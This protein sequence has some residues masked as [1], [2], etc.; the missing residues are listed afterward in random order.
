MNHHPAFE[1]VREQHLDS[2]NITVQEFTHL[3]TGAQHIHIQ[4]D[5]DENVFLVAL[6][7]VPTDSTGVA[8]I[9]EH[10][11]LCGSEKYPVRDPFFMMIRRSLNTF[12]NAFTSSDWTAYP[13]ASTNTKDFNNLLDVYL[14]A[15]FFSRL[16]ELDFLQEGHRLEFEKWDDPSS[17]LQFKGVVY[18][19]MKGA[20]SSVPSQL[21]Q[22]L[23][24]HLHPSNTYHFNSGGDPVEIPDLSYQQLKQFYR[25]H[26]HPSNAIF[27]TFG[28]L[29]VSELQQR[30][31]DQAL[32]R[33]DRLD[34]TIKV[35]SEQPFTAPLT[36]NDVYTAENDEDKSHVV[37]AWLLGE[38]TDPVEALRA[39]LMA[40]LLYENSASPLQQLL[41]TSA[42]GKSPSPLNGIEDSQK[43]IIF[44]AGMEGCEATDRDAIESEILATI[45]QAISEGFA[46]ERINA[47]IDQLELQQ[48]EVGGDG[49]P[50]GLQLI[51][52]SLGSATHRGDPVAV[53]D[54]DRSLNQ[55]REDLKDPN[56]VGETLQRLFIDNTH[57]LTL[58]VEPDTKLAEAQNA[59]EQTRL[60]EIAAALS[61]QEVAA[62]VEQSQ[63][64]QDRQNAEDDPGTLPK[65]GIADVPASIHEPARHEYQGKS[66][67]AYEYEAGTN[68]L[69]YLQA[70]IALPELTES[71][72]QILPFLCNILSELGLGNDDYLHVQNLHTACSGGL[73]AFTSIRNNAFDEQASS[74]YLV[75]SGKGLRRYVN[76][77]TT[78]MQRT[79]TE[80]R[81]DEHERVRDLMSQTRSRKE[82][83][84][85]GNG[86]AYAMGAASATANGLAAMQFATSGLAGI[87]A[88]KL[89]DER[90]ADAAELALFCQ[91]L[92]HL[93]QKLTAVT[94][95][96]AVVG[97]QQYLAAYREALANFQIASEQQHASEWSLPK[98]RTVNSSFWAVNAQVNFCALAFPTVTSAH[99]DAAALT[100]LGG[101]LRNGFLH[102]ALREQ[103]G[104]YGGGANQDNAN[105]V[106][107][108]F[109]Y[110]D[111]RTQETLDDFYA[112]IEWLIDT[113]LSFDKVEES[114]LGVISSL[115]KPASPAGEAKQALSQYLH[116]R[117]P[118]H[119]EAFRTNV[120]NVTAAELKRVAMKYLK[121]TKPSVAIVGPK[122]SYE[123]FEDTLEFFSL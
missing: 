111:P 115:D 121:D 87:K 114:I 42:L 25:T 81:F 64:L 57:R 40:S 67:T 79:L 104:A 26:Y 108:F 88:T 70:I 83:S 15:V 84:V 103:G 106:F 51:L 9:L 60:D 44:V 47:C 39:Q 96:V 118:E 22:S 113:E 36:V 37:V 107:K 120:L 117:S 95:V 21:W 91:E 86:H 14:D 7:T 3:S 97:E 10:T 55:L 33:F 24:K 2:L 54:L 102:R 100:V 77:L 71:E 68:G 11:A 99:Q 59:A 78:L 90:L 65:V 20:M 38:S 62:I 105:A 72:R 61:E 122:S 13:F 16:D 116:G 5:S 98:V 94:P 69:V 29:P 43:Q 35:D 74:A 12:M 30:F 49:Y 58:C 80:V 1:L 27:M 6:R 85:A 75:L 110:R 63:R 119:R 19:E 4:A 73:H 17:P 66:V 8:H 76:E 123:G 109:S 52:T 32:C 41:E 34:E 53:L 45:Q 50:Y 93:Y 23:C 82:S 92:E 112:S 31:E 56:F 46:P 89:L 48:R 28:S 101:V 18:N